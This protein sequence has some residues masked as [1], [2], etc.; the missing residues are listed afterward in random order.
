MGTSEYLVPAALDPGHQPAPG[1]VDQWHA[2]I[3][4]ATLADAI[5]ETVATV[6][7]HHME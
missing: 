3:C 5:A 1:P 6:V 2:T 7:S 4:D